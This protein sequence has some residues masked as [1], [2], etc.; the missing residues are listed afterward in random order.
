MSRDVSL[1]HPRLII[2][3]DKLKADCEK[4]GLPLLITATYRTAAEQNALYAQ[5]RTAAGQIVTNARYPDSTH[6]WGVAF[7]FCRNVKGREYDDSDGFFERVAAIAKPY[8]L[9]WGGDWAKLRDKP[10]LE[11]TEFS[12][13]KTL[14]ALYGTPEAFRASWKGEDEDMIRYKTIDAAP[15]WSRPMLRELAEKGT[16]AGDGNPDINERVIDMS[17]DMLR[18]LA[19]SYRLYKEGI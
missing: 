1:L 19:I 18:I 15:E 16:I 12:S 13:V 9:I 6:C 3:I 17:D 4:A 7:D 8:G 14:K 11:M 10:H 2:I 5:G